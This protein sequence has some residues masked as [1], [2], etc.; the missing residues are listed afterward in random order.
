MLERTFWIF[1]LLNEYK[2]PVSLRIPGSSGHNVVD[3]LGGTPARHWTHRGQD[4]N[5]NPEE[6]KCHPQSPSA[7]Q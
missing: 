5:P 4:E 7:S 2:V 6:V 1:K 3:A